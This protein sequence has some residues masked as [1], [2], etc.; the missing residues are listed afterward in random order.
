MHDNLFETF[1]LYYEFAQD[2]EKRS[3]VAEVLK[4]DGG[5]ES[6]DNIK[7]YARTGGDGE[8]LS[9]FEVSV[10]EVDGDVL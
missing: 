4:F 3:T 7:L 8:G 2:V 9:D 6:C 1:L 10:V 5:V